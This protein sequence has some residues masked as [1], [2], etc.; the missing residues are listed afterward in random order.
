MQSE[1]KHGTLDEAES[2]LLQLSQKRALVASEFVAYL[3]TKV[4]D[5]ATEESAAGLDQD[6]TTLLEQAKHRLHQLST[7]QLP[8][9]RNFLAYLEQQDKIEEQLRQQRGLKAHEELMQLHNRFKHTLSQHP[10][11]VQLI[12]QMREGDE[13][14]G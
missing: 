12:R 10:D 14:S 7:D 11:S 2:L 4:E 1:Q 8:L 9:V 3:A 5:A 6:R 13:Y